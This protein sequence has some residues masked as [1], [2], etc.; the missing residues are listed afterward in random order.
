MKPESWSG[1]LPL[2]SSPTCSYRWLHCDLQNAPLELLEMYVLTGLRQ[3][4]DWLPWG[5]PK[6]KHCSQQ[7]MLRLL[8]TMESPVYRAVT[9][10][11]ICVSVTWLPKLLTCWRFP[12]EAPT[13]WSE[14]YEE[15]ITRVLHVLKPCSVIQL[16]FNPYRIQDQMQK[17]TESWI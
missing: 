5:G 2:K 12:W 3:L 14:G 15:F 17:Q 16:V 13:N 10:I 6:W 4:R 11:P 1:W 7:Y 9:W 8:V